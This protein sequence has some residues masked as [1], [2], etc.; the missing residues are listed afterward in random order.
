MGRM[1]A[2]RA[3]GRHGF[4]SVPCPET[5]RGRQRHRLGEDDGAVGPGMV[6]VNNIMGSRMVPSAQHRGLGE[7]DVVVG[8]RRMP[9]C[10]ADGVT[11]SG[12]KRW[13]HIKGPDRGQEWRCGGSRSTRRWHG[14]SREDSTTAWALWKSMMVRALGKISMGKFGSLM[15]WVKASGD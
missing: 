12:R 6:Q 4:D 10:V 13:L 8:L 15:V 7:D 3:Q 1:M 2:L 11:G 9:R 14:G 5:S